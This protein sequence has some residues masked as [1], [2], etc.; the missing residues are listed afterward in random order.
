MPIYERGGSFMASVGSGKDR[1]RGM[2]KTRGE[3]EQAE[4][5]EKLRRKQQAVSGVTVEAPK[6]KAQPTEGKT[7]QDAF[8]LTLRLRWKGTKAEITSYRNGNSVVEA[9]GAETLLTDI[10]PDQINEMLFEFEDLGNSGSTINR[11][12]SAFSLMLKTAIDQG[13]LKSL[14]KIPRRREGA[15]RIR[16]MDEAEEKLVLAKCEHLGLR[17]LRDFIIVAIDTGFRRGELLRFK[18]KDFSSGLLHLHAGTTKTDEARTVPATKRVTEILNRRS[19]MERTFEGL[20]AHTLRW[21]WDRL[22]ELMGMTEDP[23]FVVHMLRHTCA[24]RLVQR[25]VPLAV[26]KNW[27]GHKTIN[28]TMRYAHLA[29]ENLNQALRVLE[30]ETWGASMTPLAAPELATADF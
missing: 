29:P 25:G 5:Q 19:N 28:T 23:Q 20:S 3:A 6:A 7:I 8:K 2:F 22:R 16:W 14:P 1:Y 27:M 13:W 18:S 30:G 11:K 24:S 15:H 17:D 21:Q 9:L 10:G 4:M 26:V 12:M